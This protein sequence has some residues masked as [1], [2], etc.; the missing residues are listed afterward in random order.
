MNPLNKLVFDPV[1]AR[2]EWYEY[3]TLLTSKPELKERDDI[4]PFF[5]QRYHLSLLIGY[6]LPSTVKLDCFLHEFD[7]FGDFRADLIV[8]DFSTQH[9][10][11]I[12]FEDGKPDSIFKRTQR[13]TSDWS[14][15]LEKAYSQL[16]DWLWK[17]N[18]MRNTSKFES[19]F[20]LGSSRYAEF[21]C[22]IV[23]GKNI[24]LTD[25]EQQRMRW[26]EKHTVINS[27]KFQIVSFDELLTD[28]ND[29]L[30]KYH[31]V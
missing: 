31:G 15:R 17:L 1:Q 2:K 11:L 24:N 14:P 21:Q 8:G 20:G 27:N 18:D 4:L 30:I 23:I 12:E 9:Y 5:K 28:L 16:T 10:L 29:W 6:Y 7:I 22:V 13:T 25:E 26:R 19:I 3:K